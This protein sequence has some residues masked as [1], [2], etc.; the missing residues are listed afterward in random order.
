MNAA[1]TVLAMSGVTAKASA[2]SGRNPSSI[3]RRPLRQMELD[4][5]CCAVKMLRQEQRPDS[6]V[7]ARDAMLKFGSAPTG[8]YYPTGV[9]R[10]ENMRRCAAEE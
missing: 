6:I 3:S 10:A 8:A 9:E 5:D 4:A 2:M 1:I 7:S